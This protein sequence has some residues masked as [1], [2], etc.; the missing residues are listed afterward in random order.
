MNRRIDARVL[1]RLTLTDIMCIHWTPGCEQQKDMVGE[2]LS[3]KRRV[4]SMRRI[5][6]AR[7]DLDIGRDRGSIVVAWLMREGTRCHTPGPEHTTAL[8]IMRPPGHRIKRRP[9]VL[10]VL[11]HVN[12]RWP[13][14]EAWRGAGWML[15][16]RV[17]GLIV[18]RRRSCLPVRVYR[19]RWARV[20]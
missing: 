2:R 5:S 11:C 7:F 10:L 6:E 9:E 3:P 18:R 20:V 17:H 16:E 8:R 14:N 15:L 19:R 13:A 4:T 1:N 12:V